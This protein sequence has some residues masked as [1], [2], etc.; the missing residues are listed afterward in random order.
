MVSEF[1]TLLKSYS[2][3]VTLYYD[4]TFK[5]GDFYSTPIVFR[6]VLLKRE[7]CLPLCFMIH[8]RKF[9]SIHERFLQILC[10]QMPTLF[11]ANICI[12]MDREKSIINAITKVNMLLFII[13]YIYNQGVWVIYIM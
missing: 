7:P 2:N 1:T 5:L 12:I 8:R 4:T 9:Q 3:I 10:D 13:I 6:H 11:E